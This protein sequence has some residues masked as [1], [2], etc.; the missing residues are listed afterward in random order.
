MGSLGAAAEGG[1]EGGK[2][3]VKNHGGQGWRHDT[4]NT[5]HGSGK[6]TVV[7]ES[8]LP[9]DRFPLPCDV[10]VRVYTSWNIMERE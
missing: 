10:F 3:R 7:K 6:P 1:E 2:V 8:S 4:P 5:S 9:R